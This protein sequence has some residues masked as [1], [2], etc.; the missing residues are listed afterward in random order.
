MSAFDPAVFRRYDVRGRAGTQ[1][2]EEL[3]LGVGRA[4]GTRIRRAGGRRAAVGHD[5]RHSSPALAKRAAEG[6]ARSG[7]DVLHLGPVPTPVVYH[8][9]HRLGLDGGI[10][11]TG[12]H[13]PREDN[14]MK[15]CLGTAGLYGE[16][17]A[18]LRAQIEEGDLVEGDGCVERVDP[19]PRYVAELVERFPLQRG[20]AVAVDSGNGVMGPLVR[21]VLEKLGVTVHALF[22]EPDGDFPNHLPDPE[23]PAYMET[24]ARTV[25][26]RGAH[27]GLGFDGDG[28]R[29]GVLDENGR[30]IPADWLV[31]LFARVL[32]REHPGGKVRYDVKCSD[33]LAEDVRAHGGEPV[34]GETGHSLLKR[35]VK[36]LDAILGGELSG[37]IVLNRGPL[38]PTDDS[39]VSALF[40]LSLLDRSGGAASA[41]FA[42]FPDL[43]STPEIKVPCADD[44]KFGVVGSLVER[45]RARYAVDDIDGARVRLGDG[46]WFLVRA[47]NTT[48]CLTVRLESRT[49]RG[50]EEARATLASALAPLVDSVEPLE[51]PLPAAGGGLATG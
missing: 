32:L 16:Q 27:C 7:I 33:F 12:S 47:S 50:L 8:A 39:L 36:A 51:P 30:K 46:T 3:A 15:L 45:F 49:P 9:V 13:N 1:I 17:V 26:E 11:V 19:L 34:M 24:L 43:L 4:L 48:P 38:P 37:H 28:D 40:F 25:V 23:V 21:A 31:A 35:D 2:T 44:R 42:D 41:L 18:S 20:L 14:G 5:V 6:L 22:E 10:V 29:V